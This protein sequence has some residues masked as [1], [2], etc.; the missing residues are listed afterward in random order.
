MREV[1]EIE[2][3]QT[4]RKFVLL[5]IAD[6]AS[7]EGFCWPS[8]DK[9]MRKCSISKGTLSICLKELEAGGYVT[10]VHR[11]KDDGA[12]TSNMYQVSLRPSSNSEHTHVQE[13]NNPSSET[14]HKP[15]EN[16]NNKNINK[17]KKRNC[18]IVVFIS[19]ML[20]Y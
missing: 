5:A 20:M 3:M 7:D 13:L 17:T 15:S 14:E 1:W 18:L 10:R 4:S 12:K 16:R 19:L 8:W 9:I 2:G 11:F 6:N